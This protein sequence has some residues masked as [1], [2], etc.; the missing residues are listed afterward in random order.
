M[1][2]G[3]TSGTAP[4]AG[5]ERLKAYTV[6]H[7]P[8]GFSSASKSVARWAGSVRLFTG[9]GPQSL[10]TG[11]FGLEQIEL[12]VQACLHDQ[13]SARQCLN[14]WLREGHSLSDIYL[15]G[16]TAAA[17]LVGQS[18][19]EDCLDFGA[20]TIASSRLHRLL[21]DFSPQFQADAKPHH[22]ATLLI[23][24][25]PGAQH[26]MGSFMLAEF[27]RREGWY[28]MTASPKSQA[29]CTALVS[30]NWV[31]LVAVSIGSDRHL[32]A[33]ATWLAGMRQTST[34]ADLKIMVGGALAHVDPDLL[35]GLQADVLGK[36]ALHALAWAKQAVL[37]QHDLT[38]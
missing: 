9:E 34:N 30:S 2:S 35:S 7:R 36:D 5:C 33:M 19:V 22:G 13:A 3:L 16:I 32:S 12:L 1:A 14:G 15:H 31:D 25:E 10:C 17:R 8:T 4:A 26:T 37:S 23:F 24:P 18:W 20:V 21:Y 38:Q 27:F 29:D 28:V 6:N 11:P